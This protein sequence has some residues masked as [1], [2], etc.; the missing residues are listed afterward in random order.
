MN[1]SVESLFGS[2]VEELSIDH[3]LRLHGDLALR[4]PHGVHVVASVRRMARGVYV[5]G[6]VEGLEE[7]TCARCLE[8]FSRQPSVRIEEPFS[9]DVPSNQALLPDVAPL[10]NRRVD[11]EDLVSQLLEVDEPMA[12]LCAPDCRGICPTCGASRNFVSCVCPPEQVDA[13]LAG[14]ARLLS[15]QPLD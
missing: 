7:E 5:D 10:V 3:S 8:A 9:E 11:L 2:H 4:Y 15:E 13:P 12:P 14:L 6:Y 1:I